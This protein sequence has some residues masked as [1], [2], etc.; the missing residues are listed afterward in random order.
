MDFSTVNKFNQLLSSALNS[1]SDFPGLISDFIEKEL[2]LK[3]SA[4]LKLDG[5]R[6]TIIG[7]S[8]SVKESIGDIFSCQ[9]CLA[10]GFDS[11]KVNFDDHSD[12]K[13][14]ITENFGGSL[15]FKSSAGDL[16]IKIYKDDPF[17]MEDNE[18]LLSLGQ[19]ILNLFEVWK[20]RNDKFSDLV[21]KTAHDLRTPLN[22]IMGFASLLGE[23]DLNDSQTEYVSTLKE[24]A[25]SLLSLLNDL[26]DFARLDLGTTD[27]LVSALNIRNFI[28]EV[29]NSFKKKIDD[30]PLSFI[31]NFDDSL[32]ESINTNKEKLKYILSH[33]LT[34][35][36]RLTEK[37]KVTILVSQKEQGKINFR[38][39]DT[40]AG[41]TSSKLKNIFTPAIIAELENKNIGNISGLGLAL[42]KKYVESLN[43]QLDISS[44]VGKGVIYNFFIE[45]ESITDI[46]SKISSLPKPGKK[47]NV[48]VIEDDYSTSKLLGNYLSKWGYAPTIVNNGK[49]ALKEIEKDSFLAILMDV[50]LPDVNGFELLKTLR[51]NKN[52]KNTPIIIC[53]VEAEKQKA[54]L[55]GAVEYF[56]KPINYNFL[57]EVLTSYKLKKDSNILIVDDDVPTLNLLKEA[58]T[59]LG[60][61]AIA[62]SHSSKV[63]HLISNMNLD[64]AIIDLDMPEIN[65]YDL[66][67]QIKS[68]PK[69]VKLPVI[70]YTG[71]ENYKDDLKKID[72]LFEEL[73]QKSSTNIE[74]LADTINS[75]INRYDEP[76][77]SEELLNKTDI[78]KILLV[79]DYKHS[80]IIVTR[81]LKKNSYDNIVV[82][83]NGLEAL[84][85][86][87]KQKYDLILMD[88]QMPVMNGFEATEKIRLLPDY[89][90]TP[91]IALTAFA[92]KGDRDKCIEAGATDYVPKPIDSHEFIEKV[93]YYTEKNLKT[94]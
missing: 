68:N 57:V 61:N 1:S 38:I 33:I 22:S 30:K 65:G 62:E 80:Q 39:S 50:M 35:S 40:S 26:I 27:D 92:M 82:V 3:A 51:E 16:L 86:V 8:S 9:K 75:M 23:E 45:A 44:T 54:F 19:S 55:M 31:I 70:I 21:I 25:I 58:V 41:L 66:I 49:Q 67:K 72:G 34:F 90:D 48:L 78:V 47:N 85:E 7:K 69:F 94:V 29:T 59:R 32:P 10:L 76:S 83:E 74:D 20:G 37:G 73:L 89:K 11:A 18:K 14:N 91:I 12:C 36:L 93:K 4:V 17:T 24:S 81:L 28:N 53:S 42:T 63:D 5:E 84:N 15:L 52:S 46:E 79:E 60:F 56:V 64:L 43:G 88:M 13:I 2:S 87:K 6:F 71:K 77:T